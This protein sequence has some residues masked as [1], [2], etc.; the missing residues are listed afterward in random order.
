MQKTHYDDTLTVLC[1][2]SDEDYPYGTCLWDL[3]QSTPAC[4]GAGTEIELSRTG[5]WQTRL[6]HEEFHRHDQ[7]DCIARDAF[8]RFRQG[9]RAFR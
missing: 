8:R 9:L 4:W 5:S 7:F 2:R 1:W 3:T 6:S